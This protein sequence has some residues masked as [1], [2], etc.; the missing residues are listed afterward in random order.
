M[1]A[2]D[3]RLNKLE[4]DLG[5]SKK[6]PRL[7]VVVSAVARRLAL[8]HDACVRILDEAG[9]LLPSGCV[10]VH[11]CDIPEELSA[12]ETKRF[13]LDHGADICYPQCQP[14]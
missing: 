4:Y 10:S 5:I 2:F 7:L 14:E 6:I 12:E 13:L 3:R 11:L 1:R 8:D 9:F